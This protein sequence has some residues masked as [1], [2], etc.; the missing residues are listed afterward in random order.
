MGTEDS[1]NSEAE[2][3]FEAW[4]N[5]K[6]EGS[7]RFEV[8]QRLAEYLGALAAARRPSDR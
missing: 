2:R 6:R 1:R 4:M 3:C 8:E 5:V 7:S